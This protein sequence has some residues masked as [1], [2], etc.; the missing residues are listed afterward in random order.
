PVLHAFVV[1]DPADVIKQAK[2]ADEQIQA[3]KP[4]GRLHGVPVGLK[5]LIDVK[6]FNTACGS[7]VLIDNVATADAFV[8][9]RLR[10]AG[11]II[12]GK[13][14]TYEFARG[15]P[16]TDTPFPEARNPWN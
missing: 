11:A 5:D 7:K 15:G 9:E 1:I 4:R 13:L 2:A 14:S 12:M 16:N 10:A 3:G 6:G 8:V